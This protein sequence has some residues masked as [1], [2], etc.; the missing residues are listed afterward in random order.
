MKKVL[1]AKL[2]MMI[3]TLITVLMIGCGEEEIENGVPE[4]STTDILGATKMPEAVAA[5]PQAPHLGFHIKE[6]GYYADWKLTEPL[7]GTVEPGTTVFTKVVFSEPAQ[8]KSADDNSA[9]PI[10]YYRMGTKRLRYRVAKHGAGGEDFVSGDAKPWG[11]GTDDYICKFIVPED[12]DGQFRVEIGKFNANENGEY[13]PAF[14]VHQE[15]LRIG[16]TEEAEAAPAPEESTKPEEQTDTTPPTV[17]TVAYY[18]DWQL[19]KEFAMTD[20]IRP[21]NTIYAKIVFS[22]PVA[23][24]VSDGSD[25]RPALSFVIDNR[26]ARLQVAAHGA[27]G[28]VFVSGVCKPLQNGTDDFICKYIVPKKGINTFALRVETATTDRS[29][30]AVAEVST[31]PLALTV[32]EPEP[33]DQLTVVSIT[34]HF[35]RTGNVIPEREKVFEGLTVNTKIVFSKPIQTDGLV[36]NY[37]EG[38]RTKQLSHSTGT[39]RIGTY[40]ISADSTT[41]QSKL[42]A[43]RE[44]FSLTVEQAVATDGSTL[45]QAVTAPKLLVLPD[46]PPAVP[47]PDMPIPPRIPPTDPTTPAP[48]TRQPD[49]SLI[50]NGEFTAEAIEEYRT[51]HAMVRRA[52]LG[53]QHAGP[54]VLLKHI[55]EFTTGLTFTFI[56]VNQTGIIYRDLHPGMSE[57]E[58]TRRSMAMYMEYVRIKRAHPGKTAE[59]T[60]EIY[61]E[62]IKNGTIDKI[63]NDLL[64]EEWKSFFIK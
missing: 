23:H 5:A 1:T 27:S 52:F 12:A 8:F 57:E 40:Q 51:V 22:E 43:A 33:V 29:S 62:S 10:L 16:T 46:I 50:V 63:F 26:A 44:I 47:L 56:E 39:H 36:I 21:G 49:T 64:D 38:I 32:D 54:G 24:V 28:K 35:D 19:T 45:E 2:V 41:V 18:R 60:L 9:R 20:T 53:T 17:T 3:L 30:N 11:T 7:S 55:L 48:P 15:Q 59:E 58:L 31:H 25:A 6:V 37:R 34:N 4:S 14:Y 61:I 42:N 13:L